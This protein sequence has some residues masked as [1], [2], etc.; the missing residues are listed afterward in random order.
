MIKINAIKDT[1]CDN[2]EKFFKVLLEHIFKYSALVSN[3][4]IVFD[5]PQGVINKEPFII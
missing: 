4:I 2:T 1:E 3:D 5:R